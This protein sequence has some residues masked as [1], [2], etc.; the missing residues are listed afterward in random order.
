MTIRRLT[1]ADLPACLE[2]AVDRDWRA[3]ERKWRLLL[4]A[5]EGYGLDDPAG[6]LAATVVLTRY[7][8]G[9][10]AIGMMLVAR[11]REGRGLGRRLMEHLL[12]EAGDAT[13]FL[14][15]TPLGRPL[16]EKLGFRAI[17]ALTTYLGRFDGGAADVSRAARPADLEAILELDAA[18]YGADR[19]A[20]LTRCLALAEQLRVVERD[21]ELVAYGAASRNPT[22]VSL[23]PVIGG[24]ERLL[25]DLAARSDG[26][27]R[28][29]LDHR[30]G[31]LL[32]WAGAHGLRAEDSVTLMVHGDRELPSERDRV[33]A[34]V[35]LALG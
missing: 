14:T 29:D 21:G 18:V 15:A 13:V 19:S 26:V 10:A 30:H 5:G 34:P 32:A 33:T 11:R 25:A 20:L 22:N 9:L 16:Y 6:G 24:D 12:A 23:G 7:G 8:D 31:P 28:I 4:D 27:A 1:P 35:M 17:G 3:E 2:L